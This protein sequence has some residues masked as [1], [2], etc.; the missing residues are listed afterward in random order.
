M[1]KL[2]RCFHEFAIQCLGLEPAKWGFSPCSRDRKEEYLVR[3]PQGEQLVLRYRDLDLVCYFSKLL[4]FLLQ[5]S[6][7]LRELN[8]LF[9][10]LVLFMLIL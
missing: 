4:E 1:Q 10:M 6:I 7:V 5:P 8:D 3:Q 9:S 2:F